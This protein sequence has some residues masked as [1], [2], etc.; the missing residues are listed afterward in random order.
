MT[1]LAK[2]LL[3][4]G[5][6]WG[7]IA[8][9]IGLIITGINYGQIK[10]L[11]QRLEARY[12]LIGRLPQMNDKLKEHCEVINGYLANFAGNKHE[13]QLELQKATVTLRQIQNTLP[14][15][16]PMAEI[17]EVLQKISSYQPGNETKLREVH[18]RLTVVVDT[19]SYRVEDATWTSQ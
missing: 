14:K 19:V 1:Y 13:A 3:W 8:S 7:N 16:T 4:L 10:A 15:E 9:V 18:T 6:N 2:T 12:T 11:R 5:S 17:D